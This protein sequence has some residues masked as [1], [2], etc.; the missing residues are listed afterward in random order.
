MLY[1]ACPRTMEAS[2]PECITASS[3]AFL[4]CAMRILDPVDL[5]Q[6]P[7]LATVWYLAQLRNRFCKYVGGAPKNL[8]RSLELTYGQLKRVFVKLNLV[9]RVKARR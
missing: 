9:S 3:L 5:Q 7:N 8:G 1:I 6:P 4:I 2:Q